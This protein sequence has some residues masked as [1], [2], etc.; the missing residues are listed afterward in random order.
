MILFLLFDE[1]TD[2]PD[3]FDHPSHGKPALPV[4]DPDQAG[5]LSLL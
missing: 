4:V 2:P 1:L 3:E 5:G